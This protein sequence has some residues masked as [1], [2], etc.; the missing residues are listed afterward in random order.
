MKNMT[1]FVF[2]ACIYFLN[3]FIER[4]PDFNLTKII[5][6]LTSKNNSSINVK[7]IKKNLKIRFLLIPVAENFYKLYTIKKTYY[8]LVQFSNVINDND[9]W[10]E[11]K[12]C[13]VMR[14]HYNW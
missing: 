10:L 1:Y 12:I 11:V 13:Y 7:E 6:N 9:K 3:F 4:M 5:V 14:S 8:I 2:I